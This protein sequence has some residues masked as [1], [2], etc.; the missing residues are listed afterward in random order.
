[1][2]LPKLK[3][4]V[5]LMEWNDLLFKWFDMLAKG[6]YEQLGAASR[7]KIDSLLRGIKKH[8]EALCIKQKCQYG[9]W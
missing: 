2:S 5:D 3:K 6:S 9:I 7:W 4:P 8:V 1:M